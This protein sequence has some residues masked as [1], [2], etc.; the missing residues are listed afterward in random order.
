MAKPYK[1][2]KRGPDQQDNEPKQADKKNTLSGKFLDSIKDS[3]T[4]F[5]KLT[6]EKRISLYGNKPFLDQFYDYFR[7]EHPDLL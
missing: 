7:A 3:L 5:S 2:G 4:E 1:Q 6:E